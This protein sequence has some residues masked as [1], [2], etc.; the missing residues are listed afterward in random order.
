MTL[1]ETSLTA[2][3]SRSYLW[4]DSRVSSQCHC[5]LSEVKE[6]RGVAPVTGYRRLGVRG[7]VQISRCPGEDR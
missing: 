1:T 4:A 5:G 3:Q 6:S 7:R 2:E